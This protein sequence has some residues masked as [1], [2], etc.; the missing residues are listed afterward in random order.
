MYFF[1]DKYILCSSKSKYIYSN[2]GTLTW[3]RH[4]VNKDLHNPIKP[5]MYHPAVPT[6]NEGTRFFMDL[7]A[8][9]TPSRSVTQFTDRSTDLTSASSVSRKICRQQTEQL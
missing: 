7:T 1:N 6:L 4:H 8:V 9:S 2:N 3:W 5:S